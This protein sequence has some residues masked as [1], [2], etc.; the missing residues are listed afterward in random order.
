MEKDYTRIIAEA[1]EKIK[2]VRRDAQREIADIKNSALDQVNQDFVSLGWRKYWTWEQLNAD[3]QFER[4]EQSVTDTKLKLIKIDDHAKSGTIDD[5]SGSY[6]VSG[7]RCNC[8][9][10][11]YRGFPCKHMYFLAG[12]LVERK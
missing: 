8:A 6:E 3:E 10:F 2:L 1:H 4:F 12:A 7:A 11:V 9:D 5:A